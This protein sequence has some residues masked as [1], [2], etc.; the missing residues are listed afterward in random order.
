MVWGMRNI[1]RSEIKRLISQG[2][3]DFCIID[4][5]EHD[6]VMELPLVSLEAQYYVNFP[7]SVLRILP[8]AEIQER[9]QVWSEKRGYS[10]KQMRWIFSCRSGGRSSQAQEICSRAGTETE[11]L[12]GGLLAWREEEAKENEAAR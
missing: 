7:L 3:E 10:L 4:V 11:N 1:H 5:R 8:E 6:E 2:R 9:L 12:E